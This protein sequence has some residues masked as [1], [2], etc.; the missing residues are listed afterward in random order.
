M[1]IAYLINQYPMTSL[2]FIRREIQSLEALGH[3]VERFALRSWPEAPLV[4]PGDLA[5]HAKTRYLQDAGA[6]RI[7]WAVLLTALGRPLAFARALG[8]VLRTAPRSDR[9]LL[10]H[11]AYLA[12]AALLTRWLMQAPVAHLHAHFSS[13]STDV[14]MLCHVLGG[15]PY[16]FTIH[17]PDE[18]DRADGLTLGEKVR[19]AE[20]VA[21]IS[22]FCRSQVMRWCDPADWRKLEIVHCALEDGYF[23]AT[24]APT[25]ARFLNIGRLSEQKGQLVLVEAAARLRS[26]GREFEVLL[27]GDGPMRPL[28][29][30]RI[31]ETGLEDVVQL[32]GWATNDEVR[33]QIRACR[34][35]VLPSFAEGLPVVI[36]EAFALE[37]PVISTYVAGIPELVA[38]GVSGWLVPASNV[39]RLVDA[40]RDALDSP[41]EA[42]AAMGR[43]GREATWARHR[44][45]SEAARLARCIERAVEG[46]AAA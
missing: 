17:G 32:A 45:R 33:R 30:A 46:A 31:A 44:V 10:L 14:A 9:S 34:A 13:N 20:F 5:E 26:E 18:I 37:R 8:L 41:S 24:P 27:L 15:P 6:L 35:L 11:L 40:M 16:S 7:L 39:E 1:R 38:P 12:E 25:S 29:E 43:A 4:D 28:L 42:L 3:E 23:E 22:D 19:R 2:S 36:M 21:A